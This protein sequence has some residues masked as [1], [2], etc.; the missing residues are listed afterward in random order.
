MLLAD[1]TLSD[2]RRIQNRIFRMLI[3]LTMITLIVDLLGVYSDGKP[4]LYI[5]SYIVETALYILS[6]LTPCTWAFYVSYT[7]FQDIRR[8]RVEMR[9][10]TGL[11][12]VNTVLTALSP[13]YG[14]MFTIDAQNVFARGPFFL[15]LGATSFLPTLYAIAI[16][17]ARRSHE[18]RR[19]LAPLLLFPL[20]IL[21]AA[22]LQIVFYGLSVI[23]PG[24]T[25]AI[26]IVFIS[27][28]T[29]QYSVDTLTG[30]FNRRQLDN[31]LAGL[32]KGAQ[33][34]KPFSCI[35]LDIDHFKAINDAYGHVVGDDALSDAARLLRSCIRSEDF[36]S[37]YAGDE[38]VILL[39]VSDSAAL[40]A[41]VARIHAA[42]V[43]YNK[44]SKKPFRLDFSV[45]YEVYDSA[46]NVS[47][48]RF[49]ARVDS[50]MYDNKNS[51][52]APSPV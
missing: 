47:Q 13:A 5:L 31:R 16:C 49:I 11:T 52:K 51:R 26:F 34:G 37:R 10:F 50:L 19:T 41:A 9:V 29:R 4:E 45:G 27:L 36:L 20:P 28:Q 17:I 43:E 24:V 25:L 1:I 32:I 2:N 8:L 38:F 7:L 23:W 12:L 15:V 48:D 33:R 14:L 42:A 22:S 30:V 18:T 39:D 35:M 40:D 46:S 21:I 44:N 3:M 6:P